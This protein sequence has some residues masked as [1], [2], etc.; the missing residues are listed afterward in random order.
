MSRDVSFS[1]E[2]W[3]EEELEKVE[4]MRRQLEGLSVSVILSS[5]VLREGECE[6]TA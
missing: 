6:I 1:S 5:L 2:R 4:K 3:E